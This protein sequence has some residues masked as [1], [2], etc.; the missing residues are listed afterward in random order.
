MTPT[1]SKKHSEKTSGSFKCNVPLAERILMVT[2]GT[3]LLYKGLSQKKKN[4]KQSTSGGTMLLRGLSGY[5]PIYDAV[6][7][8]KND[9]VSN[10]NFRVKT[11]INQE[12]S[13]VYN[14]WR[15]IENLPK[16]MS[17]LTSVK[18]LDHLSSEWT[19]HG[20]A[21]IGTLSW[22]AEIVNDITDEVIAWQSVGDATIDNSGKVTFTPQG[23]ATEVEVFISY[24]APL[25]VAGERTARLFTPYFQ[26]LV[27][28]DIENFKVQME[29]LFEQH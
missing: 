19:A 23:D 10:V 15:N 9:K 16:L 27:Q 2:A 12:V 8:L 21:G 17:H 6:E 24:R 1:I 20:P 5:C 29:D 28:K 3:Y 25:G 18:N 22:K 26:S 11:I 13:D 7:H 4:L 14:F